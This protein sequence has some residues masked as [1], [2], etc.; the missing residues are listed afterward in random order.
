MDEIGKWRQLIEKKWY[1]DAQD[2]SF[3]Q[4]EM[5]FKILFQASFNECDRDF[6]NLA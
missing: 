4:D 2:L 6:F 3:L 5:D 1:R